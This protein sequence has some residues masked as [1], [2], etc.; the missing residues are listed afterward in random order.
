MSLQDHIQ[1]TLR[2]HHKV[3]HA[4]MAGNRAVQTFLRDFS[5]KGATDNLKRELAHTKR[6]VLLLMMEQRIL[7]RE[8]ALDRGQELEDLP[9]D[10]REPKPR[11]HRAKH[12]G[13]AT[14]PPVGEL[15]TLSVLREKLYAKLESTHDSYA[16]QM[17][18]SDILRVTA[19]IHELEAKVGSTMRS[20]PQTPA[21]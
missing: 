9:I 8:F 19:A 17:L 4:L 7:M 14:S 11:L 3:E 21:V 5:S 20:I 18:E 15:R 16:A 1:A 2:V 12:A 6:N 10:I 13:M